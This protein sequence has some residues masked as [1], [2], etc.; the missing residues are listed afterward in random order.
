MAYYKSPSEIIYDWAHDSANNNER[1]LAVVNEALKPVQDI[2]NFWQNDYSYQEIKKEVDLFPMNL[3]SFT[4]FSTLK[5]I[6]DYIESSFF[7]EKLSQFE[8]KG[9]NHNQVYQVLIQRFLEI[10]HINILDLPQFIKLLKEL[11]ILKMQYNHIK[12]SIILAKYYQIYHECLIF[13]EIR[14]RNAIYHKAIGDYED[15]SKVLGIEG[16]NLK[17]G[18]KEALEYVSNMDYV[19]EQLENNKSILESEKERFNS[20]RKK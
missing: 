5:I 3:A 1:T 18:R 14:K 13:N 15:V 8:R 11:E 4:D 17:E 2:T 16:S 9:Y 19:L 7:Q 12:Q 10:N 20:Y 6:T